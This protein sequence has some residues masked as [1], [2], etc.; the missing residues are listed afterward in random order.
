MFPLPLPLPLRAACLWLPALGSRISGPRRPPLL[1][2]RLSHSTPWTRFSG[3]SLGNIPLPL[4]FDHHAARGRSAGP[5]QSI[6]PSPWSRASLFR[7]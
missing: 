2:R 7:P 4:S 1:S 3:C 6:V 5:R